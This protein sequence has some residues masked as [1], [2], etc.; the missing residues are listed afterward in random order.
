MTDQAQPTG[1]EREAKVR[2]RFWLLTAGISLVG[3]FSGF[4]SGNFFDET[5]ATVDPIFAV[6]FIGAMLSAIIALTVLY[7][8]SVDELELSDQ[9]WSGLLGLY[10]FMAAQP[11]WWLLHKVGIAPPIDPWAVYFATVA[12]SFAVYLYRK[13]SN[14]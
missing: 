12:F 2:R 7:V 10:F 6:L 5:G 14:R 3:F 11:A 8:R 9:L 13:F 4:F 1:E